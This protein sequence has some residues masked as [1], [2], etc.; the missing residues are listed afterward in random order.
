METVLSQY[1]LLT[2]ISHYLD[3][4]SLYHF[5]NINQTTFYGVKKPILNKWEKTLIKILPLKNTDSGYDLEEVEFLGIRLKP[6]F[7]FKKQIVSLIIQSI[8][9][10]S[11]CKKLC[12]CQLKASEFSTLFDVI[13]ISSQL[14]TSGKPEFWLIGNT[15][16]FRGKH[17]TS[18][19]RFTDLLNPSL[20]IIPNSKRNFAK[21]LNY[22]MFSERY[23]NMYT[24]V[25][26]GIF[27]RDFKQSPTLN[28]YWETDFFG[29]HFIRYQN[30]VFRHH[31]SN[32]II[33]TIIDDEFAVILGYH[34]IKC[35]N[36]K[37]NNNSFCFMQCFPNLTMKILNELNY[38]T[39]DPVTLGIGNGYV[40][41][42]IRRQIIVFNVDKKTSHV[43]NLKVE[44]AYIADKGIIKIITKDSNT[45]KTIDFNSVS[46]TQG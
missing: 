9:F 41:F 34:D 27:I 1:E 28:T 29:V 44:K 39:G 42:V 23:S 11:I 13:F 45:V 22:L 17:S 31:G 36:F 25:E 38:F 33:S 35:L 5:I 10:P 24:F 26:I 21:N 6:V 4:I 18:F 12:V 46:I 32:E 19:F 43:F 40:G 20:H 30:D 7:D 8:E 37:N 14:T 16:Y 3:N 2:K 15:F